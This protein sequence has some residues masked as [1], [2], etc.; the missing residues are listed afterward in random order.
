MQ[1]TYMLMNKQSWYKPFF[2][3]FLFYNLMFMKNS[4]L[5]FSE[6]LYQNAFFLCFCCCCWIFYEITAKQKSIFLYFLIVAYS[7]MSDNRLMMEPSKEFVFNYKGFYFAVNTTPEHVASLEN[8]EIKDSDIFI[9]TY[10]KSGKNCIDS[11][12]EINLLLFTH[13]IACL[14]LLVLL[15]DLNH[16]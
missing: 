16:L 1:L 11:N 10:P 2:F 4:K 14:R 9:A 7:P 13:L 12:G 3:L 8:F 15:L 6:L 5:N